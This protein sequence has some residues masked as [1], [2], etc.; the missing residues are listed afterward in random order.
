[1]KSHA[2]TV[3]SYIEEL[4]EERKAPFR[5]LRSIIAK[6]LPEGFEETMAW[7]MPGWVVPLT[8]YPEG[9]LNNP[10]QPLPF[11]SI[12]WQKRHLALYH[13]ALYADGSL[14]DTFRE[15]WKM[16]TDSKLDMGKS[17]IRFPNP[18]QI[19]WELIGELATWISPG[20]WIAIY[21][22]Q[23]AQVRDMKT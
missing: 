23:G 12:A 22:K 2:A 17:C 13:V 19:P 5:K 1:M 4:P 21:R 18:Q 3:E 14:L 15:A 6:N 7:G 10:A 8:L 16:K 20:E 11:I 9:Y